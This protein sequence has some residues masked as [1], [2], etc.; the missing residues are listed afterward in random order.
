MQSLAAFMLTLLRRYEKNNSDMWMSIGLLIIRAGFHFIYTFPI[1]PSHNLSENPTSFYGEKKSESGYYFS[2]LTLVDIIIDGYVM[3]RLMQILKSNPKI[4]YSYQKDMFTIV[5]YW[6][7]LT[8]VT[9][10]LYHIFIALNITE[11]KVSITSVTTQIALSYLITIDTG[12]KGGNEKV[13][14]FNM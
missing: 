13:M 6:N 10:F 12:I 4:G 5:M 2:H 14:K 7:L 3:Y 8:V 11:N 9:A 1:I